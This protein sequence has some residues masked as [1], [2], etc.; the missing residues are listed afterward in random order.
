MEKYA[1]ISILSS[2]FSSSSFSFVCSI[3]FY[4]S[5]VVISYVSGVLYDW[6]V[7]LCEGV[8]AGEKLVL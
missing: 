5:G 7:S 2:S 1:H 6:L 4:V 3:V 8:T